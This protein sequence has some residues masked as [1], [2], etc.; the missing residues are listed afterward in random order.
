VYNDPLGYRGSYE[1][2]VQIKDFDMF[3]KWKRFL[4]NS[5]LKIISINGTT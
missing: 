5:G 3:K 2:I 1:G 4:K